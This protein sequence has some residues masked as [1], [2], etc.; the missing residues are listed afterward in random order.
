ME[1]EKN[2]KKNRMQFEGSEKREKKKKEKP[3][4][5]K[6]RE[7]ENSTAGAEYSTA[8]EQGDEEVPRAVER[9]IV[10]PARAKRKLRKMND[11]GKLKVLHA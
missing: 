1:K 11:G 3:K 6:Y 8:E 7:A 2:G 9:K 5:E 4:T 10:R